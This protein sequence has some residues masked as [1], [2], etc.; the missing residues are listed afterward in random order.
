MEKIFKTL[1][2]SLIHQLELEVAYQ[3]KIDE[4]KDSS[5]LEAGE[6]H[7]QLI[8]QFNQWAK[9]YPNFIVALVEHYLSQEEKVFGQEV[10]SP[11]TNK[12][13]GRVYSLVRVRHMLRMAHEQ[14]QQ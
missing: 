7:R 3:Q 8:S 10:L 9:D 4:G 11:F 12:E 1:N 6:Y 14:L 2:E 13:K 5:H